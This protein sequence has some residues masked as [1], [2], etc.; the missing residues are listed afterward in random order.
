M[1]PLCHRTNVIS[2]ILKYFIFL[3][4]FLYHSGDQQ[5]W[6]NPPPSLQL[7]QKEDPLACKPYKIHALKQQ[8]SQVKATSK[9]TDK[10]E[11]IP[12]A[13]LNSYG[14]DTDSKRFEHELTKKLDGES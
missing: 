6:A 8:P 14:T 10:T 13:T 7:V 1:P 4:N 12:A 11:L 9:V 3:Q 2:S 5:S